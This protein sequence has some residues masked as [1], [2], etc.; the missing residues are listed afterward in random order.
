VTSWEDLRC[1]AQGHTIYFVHGLCTR[2][3]HTHIYIFIFIFHFKVTRAE[4]KKTAQKHCKYL[5]SFLRL[6][7]STCTSSLLH[8][9]DQ[10][11]LHGQWFRSCIRCCN[12]ILSLPEDDLYQDSATY[13]V[14][15]V[16]GLRHECSVVGMDLGSS[17][18][19]LGLIDVTLSQ[20]H[21]AQETGASIAEDP[22]SLVW[23]S[24]MHVPAV[25]STWFHARA[26]ARRRPAYTCPLVLSGTP[27]AAFSF[28]LPWPA[29]CCGPAY[30][31]SE[32][33]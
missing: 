24:S 33:P 1:Q 10:L 12:R 8:E 22:R 11:S 23:W 18:D 29:L 26:C 4:R 6:S 20:W 32:T 2:V 15:F 19:P 30:W 17:T 27:V 7:P 3:F 9:L 31:N 13:D 21:V 5:R 25:V 28:G 14:G 16:K